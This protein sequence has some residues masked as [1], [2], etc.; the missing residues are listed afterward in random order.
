MRADRNRKVFVSLGS[1]GA[2]RVLPALLRAI[3]KLPV[4][5]IAA[6]AGRL[7]AATS[8]F[9]YISELLPLVETAAESSVVVSHGGSTGF[10]PAIAAGT[11]V[12]AIPSNAD[13]Q[14]ASAVLEE[15]NAGIKVRVEE[16]SE[17]RILKSLEQLLFDPQFREAAHWW[18]TVYA[19]YDSGALF[20]EFLSKVLN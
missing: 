1:S 6:T 18:S 8:Q 9:P 7:P 16:A 12:L 2:L 19:R 13:Q 5:V 14:L 11:P 15:S 20:R 4:S 17:K 3:S 10:Y